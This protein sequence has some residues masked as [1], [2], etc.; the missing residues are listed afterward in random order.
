MIKRIIKNATSYHVMGNR[1]VIEGTN[2]KQVGDIVADALLMVPKLT[3][4]GF[5]SWSIYQQAE[6]IF[7]EIGSELMELSRIKLCGFSLGGSVAILLAQ[8]LLENGYMGEISVY[9]WGSPKV[10]SRQVVEFLSPRLKLVS[11]RI[12]HRDIV[13]HLGWW[14]EPYHFTPIEGSERKHYLDWSFK[15]HISY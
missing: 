5:I 10:L 11:W 7:E 15:E 1:V 2:Y 3:R 6:V 4:H 14:M 8:L 13:P 9:A 12:R